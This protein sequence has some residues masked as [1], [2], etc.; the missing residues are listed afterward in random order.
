MRWLALILNSYATRYFVNVKFLKGSSE[1]IRDYYIRS[2]ENRKD[3][4]IHSFDI[5]SLLDHILDYRIW[6]TNNLDT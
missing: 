3:Y 4:I 1:I 6:M 5:S 2:N